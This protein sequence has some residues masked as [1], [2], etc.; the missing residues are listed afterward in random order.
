VA[1]DLIA[2]RLGSAYGPDNSETALRQS[3]SGPLEGLETDVCLTADGGL[4]LLHDPLLS[5]GT[6]LDGWTHERT[7][8][9]IA[10]AR[11]LDR[12][13]EATDERPLTLDELL[14]ATPDDL[15]LQV[16]VKAHADRELARRTA[17]RICERYR[18]LPEQRRIELISFHSV[19]CA[20]AA[21]HGFAS[22]LVVWADYAP[23]GLARWAAD[24]AL[25]G[26]CVEHFLLGQ[27]LVAALRNAGLSITTGT[28]NHAAIA[29]RALAHS[30]DA[31]T[32]DRPHQLAAELAERRSLAA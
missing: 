21:A 4:V 26:V 20:T 23:A 18:G 6:T 32:T 9:Q 27:P 12:A 15:P 8:A 13:R 3:L 2:H 5:L 24:V 19:A 29:E 14:A 11:L 22:R 31:L 16:E 30:P 17:A 7:T 10:G 1:G 25:R 28:V